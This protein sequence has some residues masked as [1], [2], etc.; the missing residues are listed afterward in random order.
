MDGRNRLSLRIMKIWVIAA[1]LAASLLFC[2][3]A[4]GRM[5][6]GC[7]VE[8]VDV[9]G[10][11]EKSACERISR[12]LQ[13]DAAD[14]ELTVEAGGCTYTFRAPQLYYRSDL[15]KVLKKAREKAGKYT[16]QKHLVLTNFEET[17][18]GICDE[19]YTKSHDARMQFTA[20][21][22]E[23]FLFSKETEGTYVNGA[24]LKEK[25][26]SAL[27][28]GGG[29]VRAEIVRE[30]PRR[31]L[32]K[33][34]EECVRL[35]SFSTRYAEG[36]NR[37]ENIA[38]AAKKINGTILDKGE[39][40]SFNE[41]VGERTQANGFKSAPIIQDGAFVAG[42]GGGVCQVSTTVYN[43]ALLSGM[44]IVEQHPHS[45]AVGYVEPSFD[46]MVSGTGCDLKFRNDTEGRVYILARA[47][48]GNLS[49][50]VYGH[51]T[52]VT[53]I[54]K[55][56]VVETIAPPE[57]E[58][59]EGDSE[60]VLRAEKQGLRSEGYLIRRVAGKTVKTVRLRKDR[61]APVQGIIQKIPQNLEPEIGSDVL[62]LIV[63]CGKI[64]CETRVV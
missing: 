6:Q 45:L 14:R 18:R 2:G 30:T 25:V 61:Y 8:G 38:L 11:S 35:S 19:Y 64:S 10:M 55:S 4:A 40:F 17:L 42:V 26:L 31:S 53:Y 22:D 36:C 12:A 56:V 47:A 3:F 16:L 24:V 5:P 1:M 34:K 7:I 48:G 63:K 51:K 9:S 62:H 32:E 15:S 39:V 57:P 20:N 44:G 52:D 27:E 59:R 33:L 50:R 43:A 60:C 37:A 46:A 49:I 23:P 21:W 29:T 54:R 13:E 41:R 58:I 28:A